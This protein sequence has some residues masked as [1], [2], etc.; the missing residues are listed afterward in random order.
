[1][2]RLLPLLALVGCTLSNPFG[3]ECVSDQNCG[4]ANC[5]IGYRCVAVGPLV[6]MDAGSVGPD[7]GSLTWVVS[8]LA[9]GTRGTRDGTGLDAQF[10]APSALAL[11]SAG[12]LYVVDSNNNCIRKVDAQG[13]VT[14][15]AAA[16]FPCGGT[17]LD[18]PGGLTVDAQGTLYV[19]DT[20][21]NC[22]LAIPPSGTPRVVAGSCS[23]NANDCL[24]SPPRFSQPSGLALSEPYLF[25]TET[26]ANRVRWIHLKD[27]TVG[28]L[29]GQGFG[30]SSLADGVCSFR[31]SCT[32][33]AAGAT[34]NGAAGIAL[35]SPG[36]LFVTDVYN[37]AL[38]KLTFEPG[39]SVTTVGRAGCP[40]F[41]SDDTSG[42]VRNP[43]GVT[44]GVGLLSGRAVV[45]DTG[46]HRIA[47]VSEAGLLTSL[48][49]TRMRG[50]ADGAATEA[51]F[52]APSGVVMDPAGRIIVADTGNN[53]LRVLTPVVR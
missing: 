42:I 20:G 15:V 6:M 2:V 29:A 34:F 53:R 18:G 13:V 4:C 8:T 22:V 3:V 30:T 12:S 38:R 45:A 33:S 5:C 1:V 17:G 31:A 21:R 49:G 50:F 46:N 52:N 7:A 32:G 39:C 10:N 41:V 19:T 26:I 40:M 51:Q 44:A 28:T 24:S 36:V 43:F 48:A 27:Q 47:T 14:T 37:C 25:V 35:A 23:R 11:D 9:G 16:A